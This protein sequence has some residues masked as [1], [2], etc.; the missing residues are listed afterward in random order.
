MD[1]IWY[2]WFRADSR[3]AGSGTPKHDD[4]VHGCTTIAPPD[5]DSDTELPVWDGT[6]WQIV[7]LPEA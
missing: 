2:I 7:P 3:Y 1:T 6:G 4:D 5:W